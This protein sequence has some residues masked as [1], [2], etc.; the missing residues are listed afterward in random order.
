MRN[1][2][3]VILFVHWEH[4]REAVYFFFH[5]YWPLQDCATGSFTLDS[6]LDVVHKLFD[7][8]SIDT[9]KLTLNEFEATRITDN[10]E[11]E[12]QIHGQHHQLLSHL[13]GNQIADAKH[14]EE[15][16]WKTKIRSILPTLK[17]VS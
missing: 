3:Q 5:H 4:L 1:K 13:T 17:I 6:Q 15:C 7:E 16:S 2:N 11:K 10:S 12:C 14:F 9:P 8:P